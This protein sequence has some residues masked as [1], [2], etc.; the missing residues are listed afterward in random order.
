MSRW[1]H[2][3]PPAAHTCFRGSLA[4]RLPRRLTPSV[5]RPEPDLPEALRSR[6]LRATA[7]RLAVAAHLVAARAPL[8]HGEVAHALRDSLDRVTV[9]RN[10]VDLTQAGLAR[11]DD[12][13]D[14][15]WRFE[16]VRQDAHPADVHPHFICGSCGTVTCLPASAVSV[17]PERGFPRALRQKRG[18]LVQVRGLCDSCL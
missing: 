2:G 3:P 7:P 12:V 16:W 9:Y 11:R 4:A 15:V 1:Y 17:R 14:H 6:G 10:L 13:G 18:V 8:T 5:S